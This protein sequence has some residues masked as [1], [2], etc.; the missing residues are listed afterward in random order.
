MIHSEQGLFP[1]AGRILPLVDEVAAAHYCIS[2][3]KE[4]RSFV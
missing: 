4:I 2:C 3:R 1:A